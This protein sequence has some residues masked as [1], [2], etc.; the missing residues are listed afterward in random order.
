MGGAAPAFTPDSTQELRIQSLL[1]SLA[2]P[3]PCRPE[4]P[5]VHLSQRGLS[6]LPSQKGWP[7]GSRLQT[8]A[9]VKLTRNPGGAETSMS[10]WPLGDTSSARWTE[11][12]SATRGR[13]GEGAWCSPQ[14]PGSPGC[15]FS[16]LSVSTTGMVSRPGPQSQPPTQEKASELTEPT[17]SVL[18]FT[19]YFPVGGFQFCLVKLPSPHPPT[20]GLL[21]SLVRSLVNREERVDTASVSVP[22]IFTDLHCSVSSRPRRLNP[23]TGVGTFPTTH[24]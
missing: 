19:Y 8:P 14:V 13:G 18:L 10:I 4:P 21:S 23:G 6:V 2:P 11:R 16:G 7:C 17:T 22:L 15:Y 1:L 24:L 5:G 12:P 9:L 3:T 20:P